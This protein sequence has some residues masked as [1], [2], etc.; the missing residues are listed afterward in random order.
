M[1]DGLHAGKG[2]LS[3]SGKGR[4]TRGQRPARDKQTERGHGWQRVSPFR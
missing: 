1:R 2:L 3:K 4:E